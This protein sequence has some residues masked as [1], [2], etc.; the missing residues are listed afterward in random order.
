MKRAILLLGILVVVAAAVKAQRSPG[1]G[2][3]L[4]RVTV[5]PGFSIALYADVPGARSMTLTAG[6]TVF[7]GSHFHRRTRIVESCH[8]DRLPPLGRDA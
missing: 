3:H 2:V 8:A 4:E 1:A 5:P 6:G 7:V